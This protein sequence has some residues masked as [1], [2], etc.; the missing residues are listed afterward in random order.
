M[1]F[2]IIFYKGNNIRIINVVTV[3]PSFDFVLR[4]VVWVVGAGVWRNDRDL[5]EE[6]G[7]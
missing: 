3:F 4:E 7:K 2:P 1:Q 5:N 6:N